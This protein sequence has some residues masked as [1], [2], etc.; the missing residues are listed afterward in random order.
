M[1]QTF[2]KATELPKFAGLEAELEE[3]LNSLG[4]KSFKKKEGEWTF[5]RDREGT[6]RD[7][8]DSAKEFIDQLRKGRD[9][10]VGKYRYTLSEDRFLNRFFVS[11]K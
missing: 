10:V 5:L 6:L 8:L 4:W 3:T 7:E 1:T 2:Q 11:S 9:A